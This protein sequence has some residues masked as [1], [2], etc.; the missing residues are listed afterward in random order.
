MGTRLLKKS[1][2]KYFAPERMSRQTFL[3][4]MVRLN[5][6]SMDSMDL[7]DLLDTKLGEEVTEMTVHAR[8][9]LDFIGQ[10]DKDYLLLLTNLY[11]N[12]DAY[13]NPKM[14]SKTVDVPNP[15][16]NILGAATPENLNMAFPSNI[17][18]T[19]TLSRILFIYSPP[20]KDKILI[21]TGSINESAEGICI[22]RLE[23]IKKLKGAME[24]S[25]DAHTILDG[26]Y[27]SA[28]P[29][30]DQRFTYYFGRRLTH[31]IKLCMLI[32]ASRLSL[33]ISDD[34]VLKANT[35]LCAAELNMPK[36]LGHFGFSRN[37]LI[38]HNIINYIDS[39]LEPVAYADVFKV[40]V[41]DF[42][43]HSDFVATMNDLITGAKLGLYQ[44]TRSDTLVLTVIKKPV[45]AWATDI[46]IPEI[47]TQ[48]ERDIIGV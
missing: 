32:A 17:M 41:S 19:G 23:K 16:V 7:D 35:I 5:E 48:Q 3:G 14:T 2:Y 22:D 25:E 36:G 1:G 6:S 39:R 37:S 46:M 21:P 47:L 33:I 11:D 29:L 9:F 12:L 15:T 13:N 31:L 24:L 10:S 27:K 8:E 28:Q 38:I 26:I 42:N 30:E 44:D 45:P 4:E 20:V 40:F 43:K 18:D 34:D